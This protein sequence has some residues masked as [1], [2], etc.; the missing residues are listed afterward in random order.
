MK[1]RTCIDCGKTNWQVSF[2]H[3]SRHGIRNICI[4]CVNRRLDAQVRRGQTQADAY[5]R[6][7]R[8]TYITKL[9]G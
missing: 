8:P 4:P 3:L 1:K 2:Q 7:L 5:N 9:R 6:S